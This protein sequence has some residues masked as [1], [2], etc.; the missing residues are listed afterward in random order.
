M[1]VSDT[2]EGIDPEIIDK[3]FDP[4]FTTK[5][6][7]T[8]TGMGLAVV[9]GIVKNHGGAITV[10]SKP[11]KG[12]VFDVLFPCIEVEQKP[13]YDG[14]SVSLPRGSERI[15]FVDDEESLV[16]LGK[17]I[18]EHLGY[19]VTVQTNATEALDLFRGQPEQFDLVIT[20]TNMPDLT[21]DRLASQ[22]IKIRPDIPVIICT[23]YSERISEEKAKQIGIRAFAMKPL[24]MRDLAQVVRKV[25]DADC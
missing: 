19:K 18:L 22:L 4:Y 17:Q 13:E 21:G 25:L 12:T 1:I 11:G 14:D 2:G 10:K 5:D 3:I 23:G 15:L 16:N 20:D 7:G 8:G 6:K 24:A 9:H